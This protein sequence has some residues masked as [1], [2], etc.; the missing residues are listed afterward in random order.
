MARYIPSDL[1]FVDT[2]VVV[3]ATG[4][5]VEAV[6]VKATGAVVVSTVVA[7]VV[8]ATGVL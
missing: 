2:V 3:I 4:G 8:T 5:T 6:V 7:V 1:T